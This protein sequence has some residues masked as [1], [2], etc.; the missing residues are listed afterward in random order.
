MKL[1]NKSASSNKDIPDIETRIASLEKGTADIL[2]ELKIL[3]AKKSEQDDETD[4][5][6]K[7]DP[8]LETDDASDEDAESEAD[9]TEEE[10]PVDPKK[11]KKDASVRKSMSAKLAAAEKSLVKANADLAAAN[12]KLATFDAD[13][14]NAAQAKFASLGGSPLPTSSADETSKPSANSNLTGYARVAAAFK[15][16]EK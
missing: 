5:D 12:A 9:D 7:D 6:I 15:S 2:S 4:D 1:F 16:K 14:A 3:T 13:V 10:D 8:D 11:T